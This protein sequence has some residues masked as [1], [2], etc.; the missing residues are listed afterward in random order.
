MYSQLHYPCAIS[1]IHLIQQNQTKIGKTRT[2][3]Q[4]MFPEIGFDFLSIRL[5]KFWT[6]LFWLFKI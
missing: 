6:D 2:F 1:L 3:K 4:L 5:C